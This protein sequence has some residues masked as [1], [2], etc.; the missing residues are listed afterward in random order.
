M[1]FNAKLLVVALIVAMIFSVGAVS[2]AENNLNATSSDLTQ[3]PYEQVVSVAEPTVQEVETIDLETSDTKDTAVT[4][5]ITSG[6]DDLKST[7]STKESL[8]ES[9]KGS[10]LLGVSNEE[11]VLSTTIY[12]TGSAFSDIRDAIAL[13]NNGDIIDLQGNTFYGFGGYIV[14]EKAITIAN[15]KLDG[16]NYIANFKFIG[17]VLENLTVSNLHTPGGTTIRNSVLN[18]VSFDNVVSDTSCDF[19]IRNSKFE[20]VNFTN[21]HSLMPADPKE[22]DFE[23]GVMMVT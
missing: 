18:N 5:E 16:N 1:N 15:G 4:N 11:N 14:C 17:C 22:E 13:A 8:K 23:S 20:N 12:P 6:S 3:V 2:A 9:K 21:C 7:D 10:S 19:L